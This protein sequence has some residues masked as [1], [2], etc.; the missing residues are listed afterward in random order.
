MIWNLY[1]RIADAFISWQQ[2]RA[3]IAQLASFDDALLDDLGILRSEIEHAIDGRLPRGYRRDTVRAAGG[4][5][6]TPRLDEQL[7]GADDVQ[8]MQRAA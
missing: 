2:R 4:A 5:A 6:R 1:R 3:A 8:V 7:P